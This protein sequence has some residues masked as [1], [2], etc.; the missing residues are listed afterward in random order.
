LASVT[1]SPRSTLRVVIVP[2]N[3]ATTRANAWVSISRRTLACWATTLELAAA[4]LASSVD[5][6]AW[7]CST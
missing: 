7:V 4:T 6:W 3:G 5:A 2:A 1:R